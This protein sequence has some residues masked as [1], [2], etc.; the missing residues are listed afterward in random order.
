[1]NKFKVGDIVKGP[2]L[3]DWLPRKWRLLTINEQGN[4]AVGQN[5]RAR[6]NYRQPIDL[7]KVELV[8][9]AP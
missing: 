3:G 2:S 9:A 5:I 1:M 6:K 4:L 7:A 8:E